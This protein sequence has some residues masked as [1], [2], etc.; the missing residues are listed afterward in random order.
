MRT[1]FRSTRTVVASLLAAAFVSACSD[2]AL[3]PTP[4]PNSAAFSGAEASA[5]KSST[6]TATSGATDG[7]SSSS[8]QSSKVTVLTFKSGVHTNVVA[9]K[10]I[11]A[12]GG[13]L[14]LTETGFTLFVPA[15][16]VSVPTTFSV[17]PVGG[18]LVAYDFEPHG[19]NFAVPLTFS[20][21]LSK[22]NFVSGRVTRGAY[23]TDKTKIDATGGTA[24]VSELFT[25][26]FDQFGWSFFSIKHFSGYLV[27]MG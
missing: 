8:S 9:S 24:D 3:S 10:V 19:T 22:T 16:A 15:G 18:N 26:S 12:E 13:Y 17:T 25:L 1:L 23:F 7:T 14:T 27:A 11:G 4:R 20:Q 21:D 5:A 6:R 2:S